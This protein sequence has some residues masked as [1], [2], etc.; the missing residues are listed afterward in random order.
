[1]NIKNIVKKILC[2]G[3]FGPKAQIA[4]LP[5]IA[6]DPN[7]YHVLEDPKL[8]RKRILELIASAKKRICICA[9]YLQNDEAGQEVMQALYQA[10]TKNP[11][12]YVRIYVDFHR[13]QRGLHGKGPQIGN[14]AWYRE[15]ASKQ[16]LHPIIYGVPVKKR[17]VFGVLHL[18]GFVFDD[19]VLFSGASLNNVYLEKFSAFR[20]DRYHEIVSDELADA[21]CNYCTNVF[22]QN[23]A[24]QDL[25]QTIIPTAKELSLEIKGLR[26]ILSNTGYHFDKEEISNKKIG[27]TPLVGLGRKNNL[28]NKT[29]VQLI[30]AAEQKIVMFT[31]YFNLPSAMQK[32]LNQ[33]LNRGVEVTMLV[34]DKTANDF[35]IREG[36]EFN[37]VGTVPYLYEMNLREFVANHEE[38]IKKGTLKVNLWKNGNNTYHVKGISIDREYTLITG[39]NFNPRAWGLD[40][41][42]GLLIHDVNHLLQEKFMHER[43][44]LMQYS[45]PITSHEEL[46]SFDTYPEEIKKLITRVKKLGMQLL[47]R[48]LL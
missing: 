14:N 22:H 1:M 29:I 33:A 8:F 19:T 43:L 20:L 17:E 32:S 6:V 18:K 12:L 37:K 48:R 10:I 40:L 4:N 27:I 31:P 3:S 39:N 42:N 5:Q 13:A 23:N 9:L 36:E 44:F 28:L 46:Q 16:L 26:K 25:T 47:L 30:D 11:Q 41:E 45:K 24:V 38:Y 7:D 2:R 21:M 34:G 35:Y 15:L